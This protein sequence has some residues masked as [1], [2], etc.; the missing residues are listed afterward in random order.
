MGPT[1]Y[2]NYLTYE[3]TKAAITTVCEHICTHVE[4]LYLEFGICYLE[5][6]ICLTSVKANIYDLFNCF[7]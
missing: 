6:I 2:F 1:V 4:Y 3:E 5:V 7:L